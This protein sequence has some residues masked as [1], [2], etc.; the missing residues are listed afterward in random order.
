MR[1]LGD[2]RISQ[3]LRLALF[4]PLPP[5]PPVSHLFHPAALHLA[6]QTWPYLGLWEGAVECATRAEVRRGA[7][8]IAMAIHV[9]TVQEGQ[10]CDGW[11]QKHHQRLEEN[12]LLC[13]LF[14]LL[15]PRYH[16][17]CAG[18]AP[19]LCRVAVGQLGNPVN[20]PT[21]HNLQF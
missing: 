11:G 1:C 9:K 16:C 14:L 6:L 19:W 7:E 4:S 17:S 3:T 2:S 12:G 15:F 20:I 8:I 13:L 10:Q 21:R 18:V 5:P